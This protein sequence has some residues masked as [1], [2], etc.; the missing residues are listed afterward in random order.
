MKCGH[1]G[2]KPAVPEMFLNQTG[3]LEG[4]E[5][6]ALSHCFQ[7]FCR[8]IHGNFFTEFRKKNSLFLDI[9]QTTASTRRVEFG[10]T[11]AVRIPAAY[12]RFLACYDAFSS[13]EGTIVYGLSKMSNCAI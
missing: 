11:R 12:L 2:L 9:H 6:A 1:G 5:R 8:D 10:R 4:E 7:A 13:H 3:F